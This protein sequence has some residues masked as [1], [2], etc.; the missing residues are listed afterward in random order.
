MTDLVTEL[1]YQRDAWQQT[2]QRH[3]TLL[4]VALHRFSPDLPLQVPQTDL[5]SVVGMK[6]TIKQL[7]TGVELTL[8]QSE[9]HA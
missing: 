7:E 3:A 8:D 5:Q 6:V 9:H 1:I 4:T 2:A